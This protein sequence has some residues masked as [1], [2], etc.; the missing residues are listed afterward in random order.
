MSRREDR[1]RRERH[2]RSRR[3]RELDRVGV[4][5]VLIG[6]ALMTA[7]DP[8]AKTRELAGADEGT[9]EHLF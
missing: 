6:S 8:E 7:E 3:A 1:G 4:D 5:A 9:R 2:L